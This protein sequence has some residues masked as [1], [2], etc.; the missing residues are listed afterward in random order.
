MNFEDVDLLLPKLKELREKQ[1]SAKK[2]NTMRKQQED[3]IRAQVGTPTTNIT[4]TPPPGASA[5]L[6][7]QRNPQNEGVAGRVQASEIPN[8]VRQ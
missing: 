2:I 7:P 1:Q 3:E 8:F 5:G 4:G 6:L